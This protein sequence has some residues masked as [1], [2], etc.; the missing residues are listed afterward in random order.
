MK[1][2]EWTAGETRH[3]MGSMGSGAVD[4]KRLIKMEARLGPCA[5]GSRPHEPADA[6][7]HPSV[8][9]PPQNAPIHISIASIVMLTTRKVTKFA[10]LLGITLIA[11]TRWISSAN[12]RARPRTS[13]S[14]IP[15]GMA[16][17]LPG[18]QTMRKV[19]KST[20]ERLVGVGSYPTESPYPY[21]H[22]T[23]SPYPN[24]FSYPTQT[25]QPEAPYPNPHPTGSPYPNPYQPP[26]NNTPNNMCDGIWGY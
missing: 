25:T 7:L 21:P 4:I 8:P 18:S 5:L 10:A 16:A 2:K 14:S 1:N 23:E 24:A 20:A 22:P 13:L 26:P 17:V 6:I 11:Q 3:T 9:H 12:V 19:D 15:L